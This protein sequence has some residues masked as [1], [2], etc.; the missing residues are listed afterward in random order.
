[1]ITICSSHIIPHQTIDDNY[2]LI[3]AEIARELIWNCDFTSMDDL[4]LNAW[5]LGLWDLESR[6]GI[7][8]AMTMVGILCFV[9][10]DV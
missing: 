7:L 9:L 4:A 2:L 1:M 8:K 5:D 3:T 6:H 10:N